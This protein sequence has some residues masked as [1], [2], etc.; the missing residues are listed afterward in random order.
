MKMQMEKWGYLRQKF[1]ALLQE[2]NRPYLYSFA[3]HLA[4]IILIIIFS[5]SNIKI[6]T[7][8]SAVKSMQQVQIVNATLVLPKPSHSKV[9]TPNPPAPAPPAP[10]TKTPS[11]KI[12]A[13]PKPT[14]SPKAEKPTPKKLEHAKKAPI[15]QK[16]EKQKK[17]SS[18]I[19][20]QQ[21]LQKLKALGLSSIQK[22]V[23]T[24]Q[25]EAATAAQAAK[26]LTLQQKYMGLIQQTIRSNWINQFN[27]SETLT[28]TLQISLDKT[29][30]VLSV[31]ISK[32]SDS[33]AFDR[34]A[35]LAV[36][37]SSPLPL[38]PDPDL[39]KDFMNLTL[40]FNNQMN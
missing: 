21:V 8:G 34:Q 24:K 20:N 2:E 35:I 26:N 13:K 29:G 25:K 1:R 27:P 22:A 17:S 37:K 16:K 4:V 33:Q 30:K 18:S 15:V 23:D 12:V 10:P 7:F 40:P 32:S 6:F 3:A 14:P 36:E 5:Y 31:T 9:I 11:Q 19:Q 39:A 38:P 28:A